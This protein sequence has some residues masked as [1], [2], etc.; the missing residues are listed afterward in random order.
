M[1]AIIRHELIDYWRDGRLRA[2]GVTMFL[3]LL[4]VGA[5]GWHDYQTSRAERLDFEL[6]VWD[7]WI[8]QTDKHPHRAAHFGQYVIK[9]ELPLAGF[10]PGVKPKVGRTLRV[11][12]HVRSAYS[13]A[14]SDD[15]PAMQTR[16]GITGVAG[17][18]QLLV[19]LMVLVM[20]APSI[21]RERESGILRQLV[22]QGIK[23][24]RW[25]VGKYL[26]ACAALLL[27]L[28]PLGL[29][30]VAVLWFSDSGTDAGSLT[31]RAVVMFSAYVFYLLAVMA[32]GFV[33]SARANT[34]R[35][36]LAY[37]L[38][39]WVVWCI[40]APRLS[41][42]LAATIEPAPTYREFRERVQRDFMN[43]YDDEPGWD[44]RLAE[45]ERSVKKQYGV[46]TLEE[47]PVGFSGIRL[48]VMD[49]WD[50]K[51]TDRVWVEVEAK[52]H[53]H[54]YLR[55]L[56]GLI[57][58]ML[59]LRELSQ[60]MAAMDWDHYL[61]FANAAEEYRRRVVTRMD[62]VLEESIIGNTWET[63]VGRETFESVGRFSYA[64]PGPRWALDNV[65]LS[66]VLLLAWMVL[67]FS[68]LLT[69]ARRLKP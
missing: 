56:A 12:A 15:S 68:G 9:P 3:L 17:V 11:E 35:S 67:A 27:I 48:Q 50:E 5:W 38:V 45:L 44:Q 65:R 36:A 66:A 30:M 22:A 8:N 41:G 32:L 21:A 49:A 46:K 24:A 13:Y 69:A 47:L 52:Y 61:H 26:G 25:I 34:T 63:N 59:P 6:L 60:A 40:F 29:V 2:L 18:F 16:F 64:L 39:L 43:G 58:P 10:D 62:K 1:L 23:P 31:V 33:V 51:V 54:Y 7:Q 19:S 57:S 42:Y 37:V 55:S 4:A 20:A 28:L 53:D 14:P